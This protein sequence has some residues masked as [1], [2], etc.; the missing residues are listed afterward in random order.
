M[1][2]SDRRP[3]LTPAVADVRRAVREAIA[4]LPEGALVLVALSGGPD[5]L[6][7]ADVPEPEAGDGQ[8]VY[9]VSTAGV[10]FARHPPSRVVRNT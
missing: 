1:P 7:L 4:D 8:K 10:N 2:E 3:R 9:D 5:S 6:A